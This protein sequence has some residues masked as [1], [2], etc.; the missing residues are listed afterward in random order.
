[1]SKY[2][3]FT[4][5]AIGFFL[6]PFGA[7]AAPDVK[8]FV[9]SETV[10]AEIVYY[11]TMTRSGPEEI[12]GLG[13]GVKSAGDYK[14]NSSGRCGGNYTGALKVLPIG[15]TWGE[16]PA[17]M[18]H[19]ES[20]TLS[21]GG[22]TQPTGW[23][24][25]AYGLRSLGGAVSEGGYSIGWDLPP[26]E[27]TYPTPFVQQST[28]EFSVRVPAGPVSTAEYKNGFFTVKY[29]HQD[30]DHNFYAAIL[31][32][33][34]YTVT[35]TAPLANSVLVPGLY[36]V[37]AITDNTGVAG[38]QFMANGT[39]IGAEDTTNPFGIQWDTTPFYTGGY[40]LTAMAR[41]AAGKIAISS[42]VP[43]VINGCPTCNLPYGVV[44][45]LYSKDLLSGVWIVSSKLTA[46]SYP[47]GLYPVEDMYDGINNTRVILKGTPTSAGKYSFTTTIEF[48]KIGGG[49]V[50]R[51]GY[52]YK[53]EILPSIPPK[54]SVPSSIT[55]SLDKNTGAYVVSWGASTGLVSYYELQKKSTI[56]SGF[57]KPNCTFYDT[58]T[59]PVVYSGTALTKVISLPPSGYLDCYRVRACANIAGCSS[60]TSPV[61]VTAPLLS[62]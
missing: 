14:C 15:T 57:V 10:G 37:T 30:M 40:T 56:T 60:Y 39:N 8:V 24:A 1:M 25:T 52:S 22:T 33:D 38:V 7:M 50:S 17:I 61:M 32:A 13:I 53:I 9:R 28:Y 45:V 4:F 34:S 3:L 51:V 35:I 59:Y 21:A 62:K 54:P 55:Y 20:P 48:S 12:R 41:D 42:G 18:T 5:C 47:P 6:L 27:T 46:G 26:W 58:N 2:N 44:G 11:Y 29:R 16:N 31:P 36:S 23:T 19:R 49:T 43:I